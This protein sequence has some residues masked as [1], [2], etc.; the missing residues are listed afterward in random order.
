MALILNVHSI[1]ETV[2]MEYQNLNENGSKVQ[3]K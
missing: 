1:I 2:M 3:I